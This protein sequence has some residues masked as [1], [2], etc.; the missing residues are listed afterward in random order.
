M[1]PAEA[2]RRFEQAGHDQLAESY[3]SFFAGNTRQ[4]VNALLDAGAVGG[5]MR[6]LDVACG[7]GHVAAA[8]AARGAHAIGCDLSGEMLAAAGR[9]H[10]E[11]EFRAGDAEA[12]PFGDRAFDA[13][14]CNFGLGHFPRPEI[15]A[16]ELARVCR[17]G[18]RVAVTWWDQPVRSRIN[19]TF[20]DALAEVGASPPPTLPPGPPIFRFSDETALRDL[21][22]GAG[23]SD[24]RVATHG[25]TYRVPDVDSWWRGG[26]GGM[27]RLAAIVNG[28]SEEMRRR[29]RAVFVRLAAPYAVAGGYDVPNSAKLAVGVKR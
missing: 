20:F 11:L 8:A 29:I 1:D 2:F 5:A 25:W 22:T 9:L 28:Q 16:G 6:V 7:P 12:L 13:V 26:L 15:A 18:G 23:L 4:T 21:L 27:M 19:G 17:S 3:A 14:V 24:V 10:P